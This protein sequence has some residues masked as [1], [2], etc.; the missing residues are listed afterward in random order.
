MEEVR[1]DGEGAEQ[2]G[3]SG[4]PVRALE[5]VAI[6]DEK[7]R[8]RAGWACGGLSTDNCAFI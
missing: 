2:A 4:I 1:H 8:C 3:I 5:T 7:V 6:K